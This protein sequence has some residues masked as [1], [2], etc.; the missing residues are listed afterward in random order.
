MG[1]ITAESQAA[2]FN[3]FHKG[4]K[5]FHLIGIGGKLGIFKALNEAKDGM[6]VPELASKLGLHEPYLK[7]WCQTA[8]FFEILDVDDQGRFK[9][10]PFIDE[11]L[12]DESHLRYRLGS[13][14]IAVDITAER[15]KDYTDYYRTGDIVQGYTRERS[16]IVA[17]STPSLHRIIVAQLSSLPDDDPLKQALAHGAEFLDIGC[18]GGGYIIELAKAFKNSKF[19][20]VDIVPHGIERGNKEVLESGLEDRVTLEHIDT[21]G[22]DTVEKFDIVSMVL[23]F[24]EILPDIRT[25]VMEQAYQALKEGG[26][27]FIVDFA[28]PDNIEDV[29]NPRFEPG[30]VDQFDEICIGVVHLTADEQNEM[31]TKIGFK[32]IQRTPMMGFDWIIA[33]K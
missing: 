14:N 4:F 19:T 26:R 18:G 16:D 25:K 6:T 5:A 12:G 20:G 30:V 11:I 28:Y 23:V 32:N 31:F 22:I 9:F 29:K 7:Y 21:N 13:V 3:N 27:L 2:K 1:Q 24:H 33:E 10:Q 8:Y 15:H 17:D